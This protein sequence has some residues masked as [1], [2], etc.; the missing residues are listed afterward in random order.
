MEKQSRRTLSLKKKRPVRRG[1]SLPVPQPRGI[2]ESP[3][4]SEEV[5]K[6]HF[7]GQVQRWEDQWL[8]V[9]LGQVA[10]GS[11]S[12]A[13]QKNPPDLGQEEDGQQ[14][15]V[16]EVKK[17]HFEGQAQ[18]WEAQWLDFLERVKSQEMLEEAA[19]WR[20][21]KIL[22]DSF[23]PE[24][25]ACW[26]PWNESAE[27]HE[28]FLQLATIVVRCPM[29]KQNPTIVPLKRAEGTGDTSQPRGIGESP[30]RTEEG[31]EDLSAGRAP[32]WEDQWLDFLE[33]VKSQGMLEEEEALW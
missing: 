19:V 13:V 3:P 27:E 5:K 12:S 33:R 24:T 4:W 25:E 29:E 32:R 22:L 28:S 14:S 21:A 23:K 6:D 18:R 9:N 30:P 1:A 31:E 15:L 8:D 10:A 11:S 26:G 17:D 2:D 16:E 7:E 20:E